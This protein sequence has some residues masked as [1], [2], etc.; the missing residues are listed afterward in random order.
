[1]PSLDDAYSQGGYSLLLR[2]RWPTPAR[3]VSWRAVK[4]NLTYHTCAG[5]KLYRERWS[6]GTRVACRHGVMIV[7]PAYTHTAVSCT[8]EAHGDE[9]TVTSNLHIGV[10]HER[11]MIQSF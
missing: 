10:S 7:M 1:M 3:G 11:L 6:E 9:F 5:A 4:S 2:H 8:H